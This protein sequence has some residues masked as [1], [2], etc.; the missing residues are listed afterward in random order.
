AA[1]DQASAPG[2]SLDPALLPQIEAAVVDRWNQVDAGLPDEAAVDGVVSQGPAAENA[3]AAPVQGR[4]ELAQ[5]A[6]QQILQ[7]AQAEPAPPQRGLLSRIFG[8]APK[9]PKPAGRVEHEQIRSRAT[10]N[11]ATRVAAVSSTVV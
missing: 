9:P 11:K 4:P 7:E 6:A 5:I 8:R 2:A 1:A 3:V 10:G